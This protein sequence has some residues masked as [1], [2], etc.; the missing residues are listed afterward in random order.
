MEFSRI[1]CSYPCYGVEMRSPSSGEGAARA[2]ARTQAARSRRTHYRNRGG[3]RP[4]VSVNRLG[5]ERA[6]RFPRCLPG[7]MELCVTCRCM[8]WGISRCRREG[9]WAS[10]AVQ[11]AKRPARFRESG[12]ALC[13]ERRLAVGRLILAPTVLLHGGDAHRAAEREEAEHGELRE[14]RKAVA[15]LCENGGPRS[16]S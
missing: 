15:G 14:S 6:Y 3:M 13:L 16:G 7:K 8:L 10:L 9:A 1:T 4:R 5:F 12:R 11:N 2:E